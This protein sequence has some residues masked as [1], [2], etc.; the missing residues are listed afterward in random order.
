MLK[1]EVTERGFKLYRF[2]DAYGASCSLQE[3]S[4]GLATCI[5]LGIDTPTVKVL[6]TPVGTGWVD[7]PLPNGAFVAGRMHL[8]QIMAADLILHLTK[9]VKTGSL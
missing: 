9:F 1:P 7:V 2:E 8:T 5:W 3:S 4:S 6:G